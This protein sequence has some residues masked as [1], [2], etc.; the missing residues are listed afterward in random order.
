MFG[1][2]RLAAVLRANAGGEA[3]F[4]LSATILEA[5]QFGAGRDRDQDMTAVCV[6]FR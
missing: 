3:E 6:R 4:V 2:D 5:E 1:A